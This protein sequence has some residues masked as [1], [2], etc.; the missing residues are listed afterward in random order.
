MLESLPF[1]LIS[2][3]VLGFLAGIGI[4]GGSLLIIYLTLILGMPHPQA[5]ILNL[6]FF[7]PSSIICTLFRWRQGNLDLPKVLPA[8][9]C[10]CIAAGAFSYIGSHLDISVLKK[11][12]AFLLLL[13]GIRELLYKPRVKR[14][15][16]TGEAS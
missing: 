12:F 8:I 2:G 4:G 15:R 5:R 9:I 13:T 16:S 11:L 6:L 14:N 1:V 3:S 7:L 10:G